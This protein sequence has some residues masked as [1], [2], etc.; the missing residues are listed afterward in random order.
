MTESELSP[1]MKP[2]IRSTGW[3]RPSVTPCPR[4]TPARTSEANSRPMRDSRHSGGWGT[5]RARA[6]STLPLR[7]EV[8]RRRRRVRDMRAVTIDDGDLAVREHD[9]PVPEHGE[10]L[11]AV[12]AAGLNGADMLQRKGAYPAP[13][14]SP[15]DIPGPGA[16]RR[17]R[18]PGPGGGALRRGR[19]GHG[20]RRR[21]R[22]GRAGG[23]ARACRHAGARRGRLARGRRAGRGVRDRPRRGLHPG[24]PAPR[25]AAAGARGRRRCR[26]RRD[27]DGARGRAPPSPPPCAT[28]TCATRSPSSA[29]R[30]SSPRASPTTA[31]S[32]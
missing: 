2:G 27:A 24:R 21:R 29:P 11:V 32:T 20:H 19:P 22:P 13:P 15:Q 4:K 9:D 14:G 23:A 18:R 5:T 7:V 25:R 12:E 28:P 17:G 3:P 8:M 1:A 6:R 16:G 30:S 31:R 10:I 26:H